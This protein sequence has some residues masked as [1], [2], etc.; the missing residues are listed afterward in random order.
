MLAKIAD[1]IRAWTDAGHEV[2]LHALP[3]EELGSLVSGFVRMQRM[4]WRTLDPER[5]GAVDVAYLRLGPYLA[6]HER[7]ARL[8]P[9][10]VEVNTDDT[11]EY[12]HRALP[13]RSYN[14][15]TRWRLHELAAGAVFP[16]SE[17]E[18]SPSFRRIDGPRAVV[19][20]GIDLDRIE[21]LDNVEAASPPRLAF[22]SGTSSA[23]TGLDLVTELAR[24]LP[25]FGFDVVGGFRP[26]GFEPPNVIFH[27]SMTDQELNDVLR[28]CTAGFGPLAIDRR[29]QTEAC[30]LRVR[31]LLAAGLPVVLTHLDADFPDGAPFI[32]DLRGVPGHAWP[33]HV[34]EFTS[35]WRGRRVSRSSIDHLDVRAKERAR[36]EL[37][38]DVAAAR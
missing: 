12:R 15:L 5:L 24:S 18:R 6:A 17:I 28:R 34:R 20:N 38:A 32:L 14:S 22:V 25:D 27:G 36:L 33:N 19:P 37:L 26:T 1:Q 10:V 30:T 21:L 16:T 11:L 35:S 7:L 31:R 8:A 13:W 2:G 29:G 9:V 23:W 3:A 4:A